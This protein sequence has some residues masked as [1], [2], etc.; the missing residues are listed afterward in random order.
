MESFNVNIDNDER[1]MRMVAEETTKLV[2]ERNFSCAA[3]LNK[4]QRFAYNTIMEKV[5]DES[6]GNFFIDGSSGTGK[7]FLYRALLAGV[8]CRHFVVLATA[9][10][11]VAA[12][13]LPEGRTAHSRFKISLETVGEV[14]CSI[15][16]QSALGTLLKMCRL[17]IWDEAPMVN[18]CIVESLDKMLRDITDC[19][20]PFGGKVI[21]LEGDFKQIPPVVLKGNKEDIIKAS[22][23]YSYLWPSFVHLAL[24]ENMRAKSD[25]IFCEYLLR[26]RGG[27]EEEHTC[28]Y[29]YADHL[30]MMVN[31]VILTPTNE[32][33]DYINGL[34]LE[35]IPDQS[36]TYYSFDEAIE[37]LEQSLQEDFLNT[38]TPNGIPP[39]ELKLKMNCPVM[40]LRNINPSEGLC[41]G[42]SLAC[43]KFERNVI[44]AEITTGEYRRKQY[45]DIQIYVKKVKEML[46]HR[47]IIGAHSFQKLVTYGKPSFQVF[48]FK[49][50]LLEMIY[51]SGCLVCFMGARY[52]QLLLQA[53]LINLVFIFVFY[54]DLFSSK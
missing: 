34:L 39:H 33:V 26:I 42:T 51:T 24:V 18:R 30:Y 27:T 14:N 3:T 38:L 13:L 47:K 49:D 8:R 5:Q 15:S 44:L 1:L 45:M 21:V 23:I 6:S 20:L 31:R 9:S 29:T 25:P 12:S 36:F 40:L 4:E 11:G 53:L 19:N 7:T 54:L 48:R 35:Q 46:V 22:M 28:N 50:N 2:I 41:N 43:R 17:I 16:K 52:H 10:S 32:C 37:K